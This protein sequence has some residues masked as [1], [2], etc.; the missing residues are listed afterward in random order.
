MF[1][2]LDSLV[3]TLAVAASFHQTTGKFVD[4]D[5]FAILSDDIIL[6]ALKQGTCLES[7]I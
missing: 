3:Q 4:D 7:L 6:V 1:L 5:N 2:G